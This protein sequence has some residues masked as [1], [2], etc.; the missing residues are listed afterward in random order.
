MNWSRE[1]SQADLAFL[2]IF[3]LIYFIYFGRLYF[4][5]K[6]LKTSA[7]SSSLKF[8]IRAIYLGLLG[9]ALLGPN[10]GITEIEARSSSKDIYLAFDLS[11]SMNTNDVEPSRLDKAKSEMLNLIDQFKSDKI[12]IIVFNSDAFIYTPLTFD[13]EN[14][15]NNISSLKTNLLANSST[16]FNAFF[17]LLIDK[18][19]LDSKKNSQIKTCIL[20]TDGE[21]FGGVNENLLDLTA[22]NG[23]NLY[24][25]GVGTQMGGKIPTLNGFKKDKNGNEVIS[26]LDINQINQIAKKTKGEYFI[27]NNQR[28]QINS[29]IGKLNQ[30]KNSEQNINL[31]TVTYNKYVYFLLIALL[32]IVLDF[33][34]TVNVLKL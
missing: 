10:F 2:I 33:M 32:F 26:I 34:I 16:D 15:K 5:S 20:I 4:I 18:F 19:G 24:I 13:H 17:N 28:N 1:Y 29:L 25:L 3:L 23:I 14:L 31:Q 11:L 27:I 9:L 12:G 30:I 6:K 7:A 22:K 8:F 21:N